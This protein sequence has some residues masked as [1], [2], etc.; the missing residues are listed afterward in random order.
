MAIVHH[1][2]A[3]VHVDSHRRPLCRQGAAAPAD[4]TRAGCVRLLLQESTSTG[5][6]FAGN[7]S[8]GGAMWG[9]PDNRVC[10]GSSSSLLRRFEWPSK[11][12]ATQALKEPGL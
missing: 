11:I 3:A 4:C 6:A 10:R 7:C 12:S 5:L 1:V 8:S 9:W 2:E